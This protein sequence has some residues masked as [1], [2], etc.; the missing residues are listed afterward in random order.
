MTANQRV[1][2]PGEEAILRWKP[3]HTK[4]TMAAI[5][6]VFFIAA[7]L[8]VADDAESEPTGG[9]NESLQRATWRTGPLAVLEHDAPETLT[10]CKAATLD[11]RSV[12]CMALFEQ[13]RKA[14]AAQQEAKRIAEAEYAATLEAA[15]IEASKPL[16]AIA[17]AYGGDAVELGRQMA[18]ARG[19]TGSEWDALYELWM[20]ES[21]WIVGN[22]N[23]SS[24]ACGIPQAL[25]C[26][27]IPVPGDAA[28]EIQWGLDY[29][30]GRYGT[31]SAA[32]AHWYA[33]NWY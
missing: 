32:L 31:P 5:F 2:V 13:E 11:S 22:T 12:R 28:S 23:S 29:I 24:G 26:S 1:S 30:A 4:L 19:W 15:R 21:G 9:I 8:L 27:K 25:P 20:H 17:P 7:M 6:V 16:P 3:E 33:N 14:V 10:D 18:A